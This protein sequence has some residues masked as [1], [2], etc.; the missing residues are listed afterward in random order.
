MPMQG[1]DTYPPELM[2]AIRL[3][4]HKTCRALQL[5]DVD[6]ALTDIVA[7]RI[8]E[9]REDRRAVTPTD[10]AAKYWT[11]CQRREG[12]R[13]VTRPKRKTSAHSAAHSHNRQRVEKKELG[14]EPTTR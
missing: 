6:D 8:G 7:T 5:S 12:R 2:E 14:M 11:D 10:F 3:A 13:S 1:D 4:F 9:P